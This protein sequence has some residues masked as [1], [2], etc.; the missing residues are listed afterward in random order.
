MEREDKNQC[1]IET[2]YNVSNSPWG[3]T[4][5]NQLHKDLKSRKEK[6][7]KMCIRKFLGDQMVRLHLPMQGEQIQSVVGELRDHTP[8]NQKIKKQETE[9]IW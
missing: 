5:D 9:A 6:P 7:V 3:L 2:K 1:V 8:H 4:E